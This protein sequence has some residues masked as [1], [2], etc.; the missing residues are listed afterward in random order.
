MDR[1]RAENLAANLSNNPRASVAL[2]HLQDVRITDGK[3]VVV[4]KVER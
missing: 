3:L 2:S 4:P 1:I